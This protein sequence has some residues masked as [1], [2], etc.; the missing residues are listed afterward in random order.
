MPCEYCRKLGKACVAPRQE[1]SATPF[2][3]VLFDQQ[4]TPRLPKPLAEEQS[5]RLLDSF[6]AFIAKCQFSRGF[7]SV[8]EHLPPLMRHEYLLDAAIAIGALDA[9]RRG[10]TTG[11]GT[12]LPVTALMRY[13]SALVGLQQTLDEDRAAEKDEVLWGTFLL[14]LFDVRLAGLLRTTFANQPQLM[15]EATSDRWV[16]HM[17]YGTGRILQVGGPACTMTPLRRM[18]F[19]AFQVL[20]VNRAI[21]YG[22]ETFLAEAEWSPVINDAYAD[23]D[24]LGEVL[25]LMADVASFSKR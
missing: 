4:T 14:G 1:Q 6:A 19:E 25:E 16:K 20:E 13:Q 17:I 24:C 10:Q 9:S 23:G 12:P 22:E 18:L 2:Q 15:S 8:H 7:S 3:I 11:R 21:M 5:I